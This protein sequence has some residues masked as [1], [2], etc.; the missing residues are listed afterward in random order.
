MALTRI[1][2][3]KRL[4]ANLFAMSSDHAKRSSGGARFSVQALEERIVMAA[5]VIHTGF[6]G[7]APDPNDRYYES[8]NLE[9]IGDEQAGGTRRCV[10]GFG[11]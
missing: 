10:A 11:R 6:I 1:P 9:I 8:G 4:F 5:T 2:A 3:T 7:L